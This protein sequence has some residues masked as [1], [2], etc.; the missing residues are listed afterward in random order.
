M[1]VRGPLGATGQSAGFELPA[2]STLSTGDASRLGSRRALLGIGGLLVSCFVVVVSAAGTDSLLPESIRPVPVSLAGAFANTG[3]DVHVSGVI[4]LLSLMFASY[5]LVVSGARHLSGRTVLICIAGLYALVLLAPPLI[6]TDVFSYQAYARMGALYGVNP[7]LNGPHAI[8]PD[9]IFPFIGAKWSYIPSVYGPAFTLLSYVTAPLSIAVSVVAYKAVAAVSSLAIVAMVWHLARAR[10]VDPV[11][12]I[13]VVGLNPLLVLYGVGGG[14]NDLL[15][16]A[17]ST[18]ALYLIVVQRG[19]LG[20]GLLVLAVA[21]K[22]TAGLLVPFAY[23]AGGARDGLRR[24][25][26]M[27][28]GVAIGV[29]MTVILGGAVFGTGALNLFATV[30]RSQSEGDWHSI[31]GVISAIG[32]SVVGQ[33]VGYILTAIFLGVT[34]WLL[35]RV[36][37][38]ELDWL[39]AAGWATF[40]MLVTAASLLPW[41][42]LWLLP[43]AAISTDRRL[44]RLTL[45]LTGAVLVVQLLQFAGADIFGY[46]PAG[47]SPFG[48]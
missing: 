2:V 15:M 22:L 46:L 6:S 33:I 45:W 8:M 21:I 40:A 38:Q 43:L 10:S 11:R 39:N 37:R 19:R 7:Y 13:A 28:I 29:A 12:A 1:S 35:R 41:Y 9:S 3:L 31:P 16:L 4:V 44:I 23:A 27:V 24:R 32:P 36:W 26:E 17:A 34:G 42:V 47:S 20:G 30:L 25:R 14:H 18:A 5:A 48:G